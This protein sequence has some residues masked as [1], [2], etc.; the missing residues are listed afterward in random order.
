MKVNFVPERVQSILNRR[1]SLSWWILSNV[2]W[3]RLEKRKA[4]PREW[5][6]P[7]CQMLTP[8]HCLEMEVIC[9]SEYI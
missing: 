6:E 5:T 3:R 4:T 7:L 9:S 2:G 8:S 1:P